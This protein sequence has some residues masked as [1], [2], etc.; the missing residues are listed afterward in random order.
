M[1]GR[2][3]RPEVGPETT[4]R[5]GRARTRSDRG[6]LE[7]VLPGDWTVLAG[8]SDADNER[9]SLRIAS[10]RDWWFHVAGVPGS[11][12]VLRARADG[13]PNRETLR[14]AAA[15]AA[16]HSKARN[17]GVVPVHCARARDVRKARGTDVGTVE[18]GRGTTLKVRPDASFATRVR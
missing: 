14:Q 7:Y 8:S 18:V 3:R 5:E 11:H 6:I 9:L 1:T 17:A 15:L 2:E 12:V 16:Y 4:E 10:P 13:E